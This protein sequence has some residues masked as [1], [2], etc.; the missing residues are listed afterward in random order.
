MEGVQIFNVQTA[1][2]WVHFHHSE[3]VLARHNRCGI[4]RPADV[5][6]QIALVDHALDTDAF[7]VVDWLIAE[8]KG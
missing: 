6:G 4:Q 5:D 1:G 8:A 2:S 3:T 7:A